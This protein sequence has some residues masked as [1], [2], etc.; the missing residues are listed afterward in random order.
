MKKILIA[1]D[2]SANAKYAAE[3]GYALAKQ[4]K[5][6]I[7]LC[8]IVTTPAEMPVAG[9]A[10]WSQ[11]E[12]DLLLEDSTDELKRLKAHLEQKDFTETFR[13]PVDYLSDTGLVR[14]IVNSATADQKV[15][16]IIAGTHGRNG[17]GAFFLGNHTEDLIE[18]CVKPL[19]II[20]NAAAFKP[21]EKIAFATDLK[22]PENDLEQLYDLIKFARMLNAEVLLTHIYDK[23]DSNM[24]FA[25]K[26]EKFLLEISNKANYS[27]I[28]YRVIKHHRVELGLDWLC[29]HG[30]IDMLAMVHREYGFFNNLFKGSH[31]QKMAAHITIPL[32]VFP[33]NN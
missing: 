10:V 18:S 32:L 5:A 16:L 20:P 27:K 8:N 2:F 24:N 9:M 6:G 4:I 14:E 22:H 28:Y 13:P 25:K 29:E 3:Y 31:T 26:I 21:I 15:D 11:G 12:S 23:D 17:L 19:L 33:E 1:T 7:F 30:Q